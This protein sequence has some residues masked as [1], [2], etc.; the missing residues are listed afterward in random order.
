[1]SQTSFS[2]N[3]PAYSYEG[4]IADSGFTD[5]LTGLAEAVIPFGKLV[6]R[7]TISDESAKGNYICRLPAASSDVA[8]KQ[9][10]GVAII[11][12]AREQL[13][14]Q[15]GLAQYPIKAACSLMRRGRIVVKVEE[16]VVAGDNVSIR[17]DT[18][19]LGAGSFCKTVD[20]ARIALTRA[21]YMN[22]AGINGLAVVEINFI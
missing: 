11:D 6:C 10:L 7:S 15:V 21:V 1:M 5:K 12:Q 14:G 18:A 13:A 2:I 20:A 8:A 9:V 3:I 16:A 4:Q 17:V 19:G 22:A